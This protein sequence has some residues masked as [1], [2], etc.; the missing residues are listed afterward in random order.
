MD[1]FNNATMVVPEEDPVC[2]LGDFSQKYRG[3]HGYISLIVCIFGIVTNILNIVVLTRKEMNSSPIN[4]ILTGN[5]W[6]FEIQ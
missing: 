2:D 4:R 5:V 3:V 1:F 6:R